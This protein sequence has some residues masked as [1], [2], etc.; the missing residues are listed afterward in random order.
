M[1]DTVVIGGEPVD[2]DDPCAMVRALKKTE[3]RIATGGSVESVEIDGERITYSRASLPALRQLIDQ[4]GAQC[5]AK[6][7][8]TRTRFAKSVRW[9]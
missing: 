6:T 3:L 9:S 8:G 7:G 2:I 4:Y 1:T 5:A